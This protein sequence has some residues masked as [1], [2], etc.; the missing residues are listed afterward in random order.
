MA[1]YP[2]PDRSSGSIALWIAGEDDAVAAERLIGEL[3]L[4]VA[5]F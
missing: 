1:L 3:D 2:A 5:R 4:P